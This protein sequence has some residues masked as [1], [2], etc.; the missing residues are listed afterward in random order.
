MGLRVLGFDPGL[1]V[2]GYGLVE[3]DEEK[4]LIFVASGIIENSFDQFPS[5]LARIMRK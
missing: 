3:E 2:S 1:K 5:Y 4:G